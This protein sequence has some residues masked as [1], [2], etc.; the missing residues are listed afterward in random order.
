MNN[1]AIKKISILPLRMR[2]LQEFATA[3]GTHK[4]L[5][6]LLVHVE[7]SGGANGLG[8]AAIATHI[9][10][11]TV[12]G[13]RNNLRKAGSWIIGRDARDYVAISRRLHDEMPHNKAAVAAIEMAVMDALT[14]EM[15][16]PL[17]KLFGSRPKR[18]S[19]DITIVISGQG[20][21]E[22]KAKSFY[23]QGFR[24][25]KVKV[26]RDFD[27]DIKRVIAV[28][29][30]VK[31]SRILIDA[32]QG[33]S[34]SVTLRFLKRLD[35]AGIRPDL[36]EQPVPREDW[37]G[38][39]RVNRM[40]KVL[41]CADESVRSLADCR[42]AL[43]EK[44]V[45]AVNVKIMKSGLV[46]AREIALLTR[47]AGVKLMIGGMLETSLA[48]TAAAHI[49]AGLKFFDYVDLDTPF[50]VAGDLERNP[51]LNERGVYDL[52]RVKEGIGIKI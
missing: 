12:E 37:D 31:R 42:R 50:F 36:I 52:A 15:H 20:E 16:I 22:D 21:T 2:L 14:R 23:A 25:F 32:N 38:L 34:A 47:K 10:G 13:T 24:T 43:R 45:G 30:I 11:E 46:E 19:T 29:K 27:A 5:D 51:Y 18:L 28:K 9:T 7:L 8:E 49:A 3:K 33:Y 44:A 39:K 4:G 40:S 48:M 17:W 41:V 35:D 1:T 6:N 26:G